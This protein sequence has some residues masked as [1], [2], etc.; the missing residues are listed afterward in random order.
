[1]A[2]SL[3]YS[4]YKK[5]VST[6]GWRRKLEEAIGMS[7]MMLGEDYLQLQQYGRGM[8]TDADD[9]RIGVLSRHGDHDG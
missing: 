5:Q 8:V 9:R 3:N 4:R 2:L 1:M 6:N 7:Q